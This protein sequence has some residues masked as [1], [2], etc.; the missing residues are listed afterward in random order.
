MAA[1][2]HAFPTKTSDTVP[3]MT[4]RDYFAA[5]IAAGDAASIE[6]EDPKPEAVLK[7][8]RFYYSVAD[9][10]LQVRAENETTWQDYLDG[11]K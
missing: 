6:W 10:M 9:A 7:R 3:G 2:K 11:Q 4:I 5:Q 8:V 1:S